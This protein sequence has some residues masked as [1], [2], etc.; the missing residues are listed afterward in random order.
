MTL[1]LE[2]YID[3]MLKRFGYSDMYPQRT[4]MV[5][6]EIVGSLLYLAN[7]V[8]PDIGYAVKVL[9][10]HQINPTDEEWKMMKR[11]CRYLKLAKSL[12]L[13][14]EGKLDDLQGFSDVSFADCKGSITTGGFVIKLY[15]VTVA[16]KKNHKQSFVT[17]LTCQ[18]E[19]VVMSKAYQEMVS[20]QN[21]LSFIL[22]DSFSPMTI[23]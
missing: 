22:S 17:L 19:Y 21:S 12:G 20:L 9:S 3:K 4:P 6:K 8:R 11:V 7:T 13:K 2:N 16:C 18:A 23:W 10:R 15:G 1:A 14:F 5:T